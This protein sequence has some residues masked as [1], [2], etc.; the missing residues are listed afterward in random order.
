MKFHIITAVWNAA[1]FFEGYAQSIISQQEDYTVTVLDDA[2][3]DGTRDMA[4]KIC[5]EN[6]WDFLW[7]TENQGV[8]L[9]QWT[10]THAIERDPE[11]VFVFVDGD[12][13]L[14]PG[15]LTRL[16]RHY[17][18]DPLLQ[19]TYG[20]YRSQPFSHTCSLAGPYPQDVIDRRAY[21]EHSLLGRGIP[22]NHLRTVR[23]GL[24][25]QLDEEDFQFADGEWYRMSADAAVMYPCLELAAGHF[26]FIDEVLYIYNSE[27]PLSE[28]RKAPREGD[29]VHQDILHRPPKVRVDY[30]PSYSA[31][32]L[33]FQR[34]LK[35][36]QPV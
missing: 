14:A 30:D 24:F 33:R 8:P 11:D 4:D 28:W 21:R 13:Q 3:T 17:D 25:Q 9:T 20:Q 36:P 12:D 2:S 6:D 18:A 32:R 34:G 7:T 15:A 35:D 19:M 29:R 22:W 27:N 31:T 5:T 16:R 1:E 23:C 26:K 10:A